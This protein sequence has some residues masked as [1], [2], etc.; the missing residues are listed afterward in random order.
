V[1][2]VEF[3]HGHI[4]AIPLADASVDVIISN[5]VI[6]LAAD[7][8]AVFAEAYRVLR[9]G[10]RL[11]VADVAADTEAGQHETVDLAAWV[12]CLAGAQTRPAYRATLEA[13]G[14]IELSITD[15]HPVAEG[16]TSVLVR[17]AK[18]QGRGAGRGA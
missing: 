11:A 5:C 6:N 1:T 3:L 13:A 17:A 14:F 18:P 10:G 12:D 8:A 9:P 2:N 16:F 15:S 4:E 7:K